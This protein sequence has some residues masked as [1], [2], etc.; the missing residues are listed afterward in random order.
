MAKTDTL[1]IA[2]SEQQLKQRIAQ[3]V[4]RLHQLGARPTAE[5]I[6]EQAIAAGLYSLV[7]SRDGCS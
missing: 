6:I 5:F 4:I 2:Q 1:A 7:V 3:L